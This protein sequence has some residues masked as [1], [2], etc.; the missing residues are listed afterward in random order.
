MQKVFSKGQ[1]PI[2]KMIWLFEGKC[3]Q[4]SLILMFP[5][6]RLRKRNKLKKNCVDNGDLKAHKVVWD[7]RI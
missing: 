6:V 3:Y 1:G 4:L 7:R 2:A 5:T